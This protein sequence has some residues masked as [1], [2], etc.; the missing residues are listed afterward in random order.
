ML[1]KIL[2]LSC[3]ASLTICNRVAMLGFTGMILTAAIT[4]VNTLL[5]WGLQ[6]VHWVPPVL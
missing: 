1:L 3:T 5:A 6:P 2:L 4:C